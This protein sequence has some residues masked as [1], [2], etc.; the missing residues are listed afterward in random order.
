[1]QKSVRFTLL[2]VLVV[3][4]YVLSAC[5]GAV[6]QSSPST[7]TDVAQKVQAKEIAFT[8][9]VEA[10][11][12][13]QWVVSGKVVTL[14]PS[15]A[16]DSNIAVGDI[17]KVE[18]SVS[19]DGVVVALT[20][21]SSSVDDN[22]NGGNANDG[23]V[24]GNANVNSNDNTSNDDNSNSAN[25]NAN[26][27]AGNGPEVFGI[28]EAVTAD[29]VTVNG[30]TY[31]FASFTEIKDAIVVGDQVKIHVIV[32]ADGIFTIREIERSD[33]LGSD[34][35]SNGDN[36]NDDNGNDSNSND[37]NGNDGN[38]NDDNGNDNGSND[39]GSSGGGGGND[40]GGGGN[41]NGGDDDNGGGG[42]NDNGGDD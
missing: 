1:M 9:I 8:G 25:G 33:G 37:D 6:P 32:N 4:A 30:V 38:S 28:V 11:N 3:G 15:T 42:S 13:T 29:S 2:S 5:G 10:M 21:E 27:S 24:N 41:D 22:A 40:N 36:S 35:N 20:I 31:Q 12:G 34:D 23:N 16:M 26:D 7:T 19:A 18:G 17:V 14:D 39:N